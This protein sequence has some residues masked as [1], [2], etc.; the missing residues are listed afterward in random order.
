LPYSADSAADSGSRRL[1]RLEL[2]GFDVVGIR[3]A[4]PGPFTLSGTNS[5]LVARAPTWLVDPGPSLDDHLDA[6][7]GEI[8]E[9]GGL[10]GVALTHDHPD[11]AEAVAAIRARFP[12]ARVAGA[13]GDVDVRLRDGVNFGPL[14]AMA[15][16][17]H[18]PDN[19]TFIVEDGLGLTG[20]LVLGQGSSLIV[21]YPGALADYL[22]SL[23]RLRARRLALLAPG[24]GPPV[25]DVEAKLEEYI[26]HRLE[27][28]R[29]LVAALEAGKRTADEL[30]DDAWSDAPPG[31]R[32]A[33]A[34]TLAAHLDK[35]AAEGR[36]PDGVE[37]PQ[38][39]FPGG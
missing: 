21:P 13:R 31:L 36:L 22:D 16:P 23:R 26:A 9:R 39:S 25:N 14:E 10:G 17:G 11:H 3:A 12:K 20:D 7:M 38:I 4:N 33:A 24:H 30:L 8:A 18:A 37:R 1:T 2:P 15:T 35:L 28:E 34:A 19:V 6:L 29:R 32:P 27:R 5:W